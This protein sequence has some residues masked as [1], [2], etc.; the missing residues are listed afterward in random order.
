MGTMMRD[1]QRRSVTR[2]LLAIMVIAWMATIV[3]RP[4]TSAASAID[5]AEDVPVLAYYY[6]WYTPSSWSRAKS[7]LPLLGPYSSDDADVMRDHIRWAKAAGI[8]GFIVSWKDTE[9]L[10]R[11]L[12]QLVEIAREES[13]A[14]T[15]NYESLD[16]SRDPLPVEKVRAD[17]RL[18]ADMYADD[19][20][21]GLFGRPVVIWSGTWKYERSDIEW[22][23]Q[24]LRDQLRLL[25]SQKQP[26]AYLEIADLVDGNAYYWSS[27]NPDTYPNYAGKLRDMADAVHASG[28]LWI[29]PAAPGFDARHLGGEQRVDRQ[30][31]AMLK[32]QLETALSSGPDAVGLI[33]WNEFSENSHIEPSCL[34]GARYLE[35]I[36]SLIGGTPPDVSLRCDEAALATARAGT[37]AD[38]TA[39]PP[40][41]AGSIPSSSMF[42]WDSNAPEGR[43]RLN[44]G[45]RGTVLLAPLSALMLLSVFVVVRRSLRA[46]MEPAGHPNPDGPAQE[47]AAD[48]TP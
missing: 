43:A 48:D 33:S 37:N 18:F 12:R 6:I 21:F 31:G 11:R 2:C 32:T 13:F 9:A 15:I 38:L 10:T 14:L 22:V 27:V 3:A 46:P 36:A 19:P 47:E 40:V 42:D 28:G 1:G 41:D 17:L 29:A 8:D 24:D 25:A 44:G 35:T 20:V 23:A 26:S 5:G 45:V 34:Y 4:A 39:S 30:D 7:D 16:F